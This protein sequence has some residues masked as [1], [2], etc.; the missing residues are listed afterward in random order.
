MVPHLFLSVKFEIDANRENNLAF[1][2][3]FILLINIRN[4]IK[5]DDIMFTIRLAALA[6]LGLSL[7]LIAHP[8]AQK[9]PH[10]IKLEE[11]LVNI[12]ARITALEQSGKRPNPNSK[13][14]RQW[15]KLAPRLDR[16]KVVDIP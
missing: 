16:Q 11:R 2:Y 6:L 7:G 9:C 3:V 5:K 10:M 4:T 15:N 1:S 8:E 13:H 12:E 14:P